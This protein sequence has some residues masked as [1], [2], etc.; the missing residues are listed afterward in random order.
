MALADTFEIGLSDDDIDVDISQAWYLFND[1]VNMLDANS[2]NA[3]RLYKVFLEFRDYNV[4]ELLMNR[5]R[6]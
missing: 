1:I 2:E 6:E 5:F 3:E 4:F